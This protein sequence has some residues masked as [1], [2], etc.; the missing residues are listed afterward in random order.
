M[1]VVDA[2]SSVFSKIMNGD[3]MSE[4]RTLLDRVKELL[5]IMD[6]DDTDDNSELEFESTNDC[7]QFIVRDQTDDRFYRIDEMNYDKV[8]DVHV[9]EVKP[10]KVISTRYR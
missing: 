7:D 1:V 6:S 9:I 3:F 10:Y 5:W 8:E 2:M 4:E